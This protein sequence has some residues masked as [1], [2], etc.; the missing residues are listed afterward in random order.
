MMV[1]LLLSYAYHADTDLA[2]VRKAIGPDALLLIDSGAFTA[3]STG[4]PIRLG[5][6]AAYLDRWA[7]FIDAAITLDVIGDPTAT[8]AN[9][10]TLYAMGHRVIPVHTTG[11]P[12]ATF[13]AACETGY[14]AIGGIAKAGIGNHRLRERYVTMLVRRARQ[15]GAVL[16][17]LGVGG[18]AMLRCGAYSADSSGYITTVSHRYNLWVWDIRRHRPVQIN[19]GDKAA[20]T[21][22]RHTLTGLGI[23]VAR[24]CAGGVNVLGYKSGMRTELM[25]AAAWTWL[26]A[27]H[28][29]RVTP[30]PA[31]RPGWVPGPRMVFA[32]SPAVEDLGP[33]LG[34]ADAITTGAVPPLVARILH[35]DQ[36]TP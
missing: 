5:D 32:A 3:H 2:A 25:T 20:L 24:L 9:T 15:R 28:L 1:N 19:M 30:V 26:I 35:N 4:K 17:L 12:L 13:D 23:D 18:A 14:V 7:P 31:P 6:Y 10:A 27:A 34:I 16:H 11:G 33:L 29:T 8:A 22:H 36:G 21:R